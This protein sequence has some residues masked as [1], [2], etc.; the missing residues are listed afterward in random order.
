[1]RTLNATPD[2]LIRSE[3]RASWNAQT[4]KGDLAASGIY[5]ARVDI[6]GQTQSFRLVLLR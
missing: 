5:F 4:E 3:F 2:A 1:V 6:L